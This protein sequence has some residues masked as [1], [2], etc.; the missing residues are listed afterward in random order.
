MLGILVFGNNHLILR[1]PLP[2]RT[3]TL[4]LVRNS[5]L[6]QIGSATPP[7][8]DRWRISTREFRENLQWAVVAPGDGEVTRAVAELL[9]E[10]SARGIQI[11]DAGLSDW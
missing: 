4:A 8:L 2:D 6:I 7:S 10:L 3:A 9:Q 5:S 11:H 1:G